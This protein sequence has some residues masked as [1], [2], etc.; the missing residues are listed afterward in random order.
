MRAVDWGP[1]LFDWRFARFRELD[2]A[3]KDASLRG[4]M[5]SSLAL[6]R[7]A[8][9]ALKN[10]SMLGWYS[11]D[12]SWASIGYQGPLIAR[13]RG[14]VV[15]V[16][17]AAA[18]DEVAALVRRVR[19]RL[20]RRRRGRGR[21]ARA[22][23]A[24][25]RRARA[26][27]ALDEQGLHAAR[28]GHAPAPLRGSGPAPDRGRLDHHPPGPQRGRLDRPQPLLRVPHARSDPRALARRARPR[29]RSRPRRSRR[30]SSASRRRSR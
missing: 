30:A 3:G 2:D 17:L 13:A 10:L 4:W 7:L 24:R 27:P 26:G 6:R 16:D 28:G 20:G 14:D 15:S 1:Y 5:T 8:F 19:D 9:Q 11:Q 12:A 22:R 23:R 29:R 18:T 25:R 21:R